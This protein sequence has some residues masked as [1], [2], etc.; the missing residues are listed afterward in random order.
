MQRLLQLLHYSL[1][2]VIVWAAGMLAAAEGGP[3][4]LVAIPLALLTVVTVDRLQLWSVPVSIANVLGVIAFFVSG[5]EFLSGD[6]ER[7]VITAGHVLTY[8]TCIF[9][10]QKKATKQIWLLLAMS[11][12]EVA[13]ASIL[14]TDAWLGPALLMYVLAALWTLSVFSLYRA[15]QRV[16]EHATPAQGA[17][18][19]PAATGSRIRHGVRAERSNWVNSRF[20]IGGLTATFLSVILAVGFFLFIPRMW[21]SGLTL[22]AEDSQPLTGFAETVS[23]GDVGELMESADLVFDVEFQMFGDDRPLTPNEVAELVPGEHMY[24]GAVLE[25]YSDGRWTLGRDRELVRG[26]PV[27]APE[28]RH[29]L[30]QTVRLQPIGTKMLFGLGFPVAAIDAHPIEEN[31]TTE[32]FL[33]RRSYEIQ[34]RN[35]AANE[36]LTYRAFSRFTDPVPDTPTLEAEIRRKQYLNSLTRVPLTLGAL[37]DFAAETVGTKRPRATR[38]HDAASRI[39]K[40]LRDSQDFTYTMKQVVKDPQVDPLVDFVVN[41]KSGHCEYYASAMTMMLRSLSIPARMIS[42][43]KG[44]QFNV[45]DNRYEVRQLHAH[46]W[47]EAYVDDHWVTFDPTPGMRDVSVQE[48]VDAHANSPIANL[49]D[50]SKNLWGQSMQMTKDQQQQYLYQPIRERAMFLWNIGTG[51][52]SGKISPYEVVQS[53]RRPERWFSWQ[54]GIVTVI[55]GVTLIGLSRAIRGTIAWARGRNSNKGRKTRQQIS[56]EFYERLMRILH[57]AGYEPR[58]AQTAREFVDATIPR[59]QPR[60]AEQGIDPKGTRELVEWFYDVRFGGDALPQSRIEEIDRRLERIEVSLKETK[61][62]PSAR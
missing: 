57:E 21:I 53:I 51:L 58:P 10:V 18:W 54:G 26:F 56:V 48:M 23:L 43:F 25:Q 13:V 34:R 22:R 47:V 7:R 40:R 6:L 8:L 20:V 5:F 30:V 38:Q 49:L 35:V 41:R 27:P 60:L 19:T 39:E 61:G 16:S 24:R 46:T 50:S 33:D 1:A 29:L 55:I 42:G 11:I 36:L 45:K 3:V 31:R 12:L 14:T 59:I 15:G 2:F 44:G 9:L 32:I 4:P 62:K 28:R 37:A 52:L 17:A